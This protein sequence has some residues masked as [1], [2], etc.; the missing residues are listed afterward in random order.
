MKSGAT[1]PA[2]KNMNYQYAHNMQSC[3]VQKI[4]IFWKEKQ[5][6]LNWL[7]TFMFPNKQAEN[8]AQTDTRV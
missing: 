4:N 3:K 5:A 8:N 7:V 6:D 2:A 1:P